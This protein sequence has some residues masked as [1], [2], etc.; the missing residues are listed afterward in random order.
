MRFTCLV[1]C[2]VT[3]F[4]KRQLRGD[5][6]QRSAMEHKPVAAANEPSLHDAELGRQLKMSPGPQVPVSFSSLLATNLSSHFLVPRR[7]RRR[8]R[9]RRGYLLKETFVFRRLCSFSQSISFTLGTQVG[10]PDREA[11]ALENVHASAELFCEGILQLHSEPD[12]SFNVLF[13]VS[14]GRN[15]RRH[16]RRHARPEHAGHCTHRRGSRGDPFG[17]RSIHRLRA[18][19]RGLRPSP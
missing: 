18:D 16:R 4:G 11:Q 17:R 13:Q 2:L 12:L 8:R 6:G 10:P 19:E 3:A 5:D 1:L 7:R 14:R 9:R 15:H